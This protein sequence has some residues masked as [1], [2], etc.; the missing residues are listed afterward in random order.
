MREGSSSMAVLSKE[1]PTTTRPS[2]PSSLEAGFAR[3]GFEKD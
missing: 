3:R 1:G 2:T